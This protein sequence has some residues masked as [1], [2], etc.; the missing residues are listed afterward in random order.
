MQTS[1]KEI[2]YV[3][4]LFTLPVLRINS[5]YGNRK[6]SILIYL[7]EDYFFN[8]SWLLYLQLGVLFYVFSQLTNQLYPKMWHARFW[9][10]G[11]H[12]ISDIYLF[13]QLSYTYFGEQR[14]IQKGIQCDFSNYSFT[15]LNRGN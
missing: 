14:S 9:Y 1:T 2:F 3:G 12:Y 13:G 8:I 6:I 4:Y 10:D 5:E 7:E 15:N 11:H